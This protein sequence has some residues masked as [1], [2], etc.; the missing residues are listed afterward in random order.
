MYTDK[1][2]RVNSQERESGGGRQWN[3][4]LTHLS[5][6]SGAGSHMVNVHDAAPHTVSDCEQV[7]VRFMARVMSG[8]QGNF[9]FK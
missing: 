4:N 3:L 2:V 8:G 6:L 7:K 9:N 1:A 5:H